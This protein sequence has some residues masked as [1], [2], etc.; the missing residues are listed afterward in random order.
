MILNILRTR[1]YHQR[2]FRLLS[3]WIRNDMFFSIA[4]AQN[5]PLFLL[6]AYKGSHVNATASTQPPR[7]W[8]RLQDNKMPLHVCPIKTTL[9]PNFLLV[10]VRGRKLPVRYVEE[11][12][13]LTHWNVMII[14]IVIIFIIMY[15]H[16]IHGW[17]SPLSLLY[18]RLRMVRFVYNHVC[19]VTYFYTFS[20]YPQISRVQPISCVIK[21][22]DV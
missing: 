9:R 1:V 19:G 7:A 3:Y 13:P 16:R 21:H 18:Q 10:R 20:W 12:T 17:L 2:V 8:P 22:Y 4:A 6:H 5:S 11:K 14:F 15:K